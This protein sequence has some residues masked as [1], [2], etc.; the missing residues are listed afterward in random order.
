MK[1]TIFF[2]TLSLSLNAFAQSQISCTSAD[3]NTSVSAIPLSF[4]PV[5]RPDS[6]YI[7]IKRKGSRDEQGTVYAMTLGSNLIYV[8][9]SRDNGTDLIRLTLGKMNDQNVYPRAK[10]S[11]EKGAYLDATDRVTK[12]LSEKHDLKCT[13]SE[14]PGVSNVCSEEEDTAYNDALMN[15]AYNVDMDKAE[16]ALACGAD[17]NSVNEFGCTPL[18]ISIGVDSLDCRSTNT[19][20]NDSF[21]SWRANYIFKLLLS[22]GALTHLTDKSGETI[23]H[24][25]VKLGKSELVPTLAKD[26]ADLNIQDTQGMTAVMRAALNRNE[27]AVKALVEAKVD[28]TKKN[29]LGQTAYDLGE[30]LDPSVR[31]L[32][33][34]GN[35]EGLVI[36]GGTD[37]KCTPSRIQIV[38][39]K[40]TKITLKASPNQM[41]LMTAKDLKIEL[42]AEAGKTASTV[43][44]TNKMGTFRFQCGVHGGTM[45]NG[46]I[47]IVH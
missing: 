11:L 39:G 33:I 43:V 45:T 38:M 25:V 44:T 24:K 32:L 31:K 29:I 23:A 17:V 35:D 5:G 7:T 4:I 40:A 19:A 47:T 2:L 27:K 36:Q 6:H 15:A 14:A 21:R 37:G 41:F 12:P 28:L 3:G 10:L 30:K 13:L 34:P 1:T 18:M 20:P 26:N 22:E 42:M 16:Q 9:S 8:N 46:Q